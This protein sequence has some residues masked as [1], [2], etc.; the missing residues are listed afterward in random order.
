MPIDLYYISQSPPCRAVMM[1]TYLAGVDL[2]LPDEPRIPDNQPAAQRPTIVD[3]GFCLN[4][5][6]AISAYLINRY[7]GQNSFQKFFFKE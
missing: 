1:T 4:E 5:S 3:D 7:G 6:Q 2:N